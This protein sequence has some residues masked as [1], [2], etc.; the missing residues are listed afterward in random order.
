MHFLRRVDT[1]H[2]ILPI[3]PST[4]AHLYY[5]TG[6]GSSRSCLGSITSACY[7]HRLTPAPTGLPVWWTSFAR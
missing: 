4:P 3:H 5:S 6:S 1:H 2:P 7:C